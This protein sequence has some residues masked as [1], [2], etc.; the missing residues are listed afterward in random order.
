MYVEDA[1][2]NAGYIRLTTYEVE[3]LAKQ[4][5][6]IG[7]ISRKITKADLLPKTKIEIVADDKEIAKTGMIRDGKSLYPL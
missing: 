1:L 2:A 3:G 4:S 7:N 5:G 6:I